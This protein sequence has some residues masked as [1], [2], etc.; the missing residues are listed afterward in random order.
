MCQRSSKTDQDQMTKSKSFWDRLGDALPQVLQLLAPSDLHA[1]SLVNKTCYAEIEPFLYSKIKWTWV[2]DRP[3]PIEPF[4]RTILQRPELALHVRDFALV[5]GKSFVYELP[6]IC[7]N[8]IDLDQALRPFE[9]MPMSF[10]DQWRQGLQRGEMD[11]FVTLLLCKLHRLDQFTLHNSSLGADL[12]AMLLRLVLCKDSEVSR[13]GWPISHHLRRISHTSNGDPQVPM[14]GEHTENVLAYFYLPQLEE[15][16]VSLWNP[17]SIVWPTIKPDASTL[18]SLQVTRIREKPLADLL[19]ATPKLERLQWEWHYDPDEEHA[20]NSPSVKLD[21]LA[22]AIMP[23]RDSLI[24]LSIEASTYT[25]S[26]YMSAPELDF[27]GSPQGFTK[28]CRLEKLCIPLVFLVTFRPTNTIRLEDVLPESMRSLTM[29][30][31]LIVQEVAYERYTGELQNEW[32]GMAILG[33][34]ESWL[35]ARDRVSPAIQEV[36]LLLQLDTEFWRMKTF[37]NDLARLGDDHGIR[38]EL[39]ERDWQW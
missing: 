23:I 17:A 10:I 16:S 29:N 1:L 19:L 26:A 15:L 36:V 8:G 3:P 37:S 24:E 2:L 38:V 27:T 6:Q 34:V 31:D 4:L 25:G 18:R 14:L 30:D 11:A 5:G 12:Q 20:A 21:E 7:S 28:L 22:S 35:A 32:D 13:C 9:A 39:R 33:L